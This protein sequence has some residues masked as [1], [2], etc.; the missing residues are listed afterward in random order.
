MPWDWRKMMRG[1]DTP[2]WQEHRIAGYVD[3][4]TTLDGAREAVA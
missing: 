3:D 4:V 2:G 1:D